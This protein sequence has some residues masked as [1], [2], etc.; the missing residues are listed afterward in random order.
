MKNINFSIKFSLFLFQTVTTLQW[1]LHSIAKDSKFQDN[2]RK[3]I[4]DEPGNLESPLVRATLR[5]S[6]RLYPVAPF[7]G[8]FMEND[9]TIGEYGIPKGV[10]ALA[11]L[12]TSGRDPANF[13]DSHKFIPDRWLRN[14]DQSEHKVFKSHATLPF[15]MG[16]RSCV[17]KK[18]AS[19]QIHCLITKV[20]SHHLC[21]LNIWI[22]DLKGSRFSFSVPYVF[23]G[24]N[25]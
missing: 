24:L 19:Y 13:T 23:S 11:S 17:G 25:G 12:Y 3:S 8:R 21:M 2:L 10:L 1:I 7:V 18:I 20:T 16:S 14:G 4:T 6:L 9:A 22:A 15:S 5:E